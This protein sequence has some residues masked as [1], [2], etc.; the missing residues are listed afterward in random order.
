MFAVVKKQMVASASHLTECSTNNGLGRKLATVFD[1]M[2]GISA[3]TRDLIH[4]RAFDLEAR[5]GSIGQRARPRD[6]T[7]AVGEVHNRIIP[8]VDAVMLKRHAFPTTPNKKMIAFRQS[9]FLRFSFA[10]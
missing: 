3:A 8:K 10:S 9:R 2:Q 1:E 5:G 7:V 4:W 6:P